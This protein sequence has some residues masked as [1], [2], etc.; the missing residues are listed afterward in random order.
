MP[1]DVCPMLAIAY[2]VYSLLLCSYQSFSQFFLKSIDVLVKQ[3]RPTNIICPMAITGTVRGQ[4]AG[5]QLA[6]GQ[7]AGGQLA[8]DF[9]GG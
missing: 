3:K 9:F 1:I 2:F 5:G 7:Q 8:G 4:L 6:G